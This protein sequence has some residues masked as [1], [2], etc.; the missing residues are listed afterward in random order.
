[1]IAKDDIVSLARIDHIISV[2][3]KDEVVAAGERDRIGSACHWRLRQNLLQLVRVSEVGSTGI[4]QHEEF[5]GCSGDRIRS[6]NRVIASSGDHYVHS[7]TG[8]HCVVTTARVVQCLD[9]AI[10]H[11]TAESTNDT[12]S[13]VTEHGIVSA[14][15]R[16]DIIGRSR[17]DCIRAA[18]NRD[19]IHTADREALTDNARLVTKVCCRDLAVIT[20]HCCS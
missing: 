18:G 16:H 12:L 1:M 6:R 2:T 7:T 15:D 8:R 9:K 11:S 5:R 14:G 13:V 3:T 19:A 4:T 17:N 10:G 20:Q